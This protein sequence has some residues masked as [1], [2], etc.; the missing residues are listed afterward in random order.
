LNVLLLDI[1][2][3][4]QI[5]IPLC[6]WSVY[7]LILHCSFVGRCATTALW[8]DPHYAKCWQ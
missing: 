7:L 3:F 8:S 1:I 6:C 4:Q 2:V 5:C